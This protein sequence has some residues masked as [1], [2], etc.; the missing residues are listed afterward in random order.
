[1]RCTCGTETHGIQEENGLWCESCGASLG[2][3]AVFVVGYCQSHSRRNQVYSRRKRF[4]KYVLSV[5]HN[6]TILRAYYKILDLYSQYEFVWMA[7][8]S[9]RKYF[10]AKPVML[11]VCCA[12]LDLCSE[13]DLGRLP[14]LKDRNREADQARQ[15]E[16]LRA[17]ECWRQSYAMKND[18]EEASY[19]TY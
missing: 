15:L 6:K 2:E 9:E 12:V 19:F 18:T 13:A 3:G 11:K 5:V 8:P 14:S 7:T 4:G 17:T 16:S 10:F 1:M